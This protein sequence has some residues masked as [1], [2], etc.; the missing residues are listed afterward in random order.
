VFLLIVLLNAVMTYYTYFKDYE[1]DRIAGKRTFIVRYGMDK[2]RK[3]GI[4]GAF[5]PM[6]AFILF[7]ALGWLPGNELKISLL[8]ALC[9]AFAV[10][11]QIWTA[12]L[13]YRR[14]TGDQA[15]TNLA[16]GIRACVSGQIALIALM[17]GVLAVCLL[18]AS[19]SLIG[20]LFGLHRDAKA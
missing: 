19:Y 18:I 7:M 4:I 20:M 5:I 14:P 11:L 15:Y 6:A 16:M 1:G 3:A 2:A 10:S 9:A 8:F 17:N 12:L 13:F